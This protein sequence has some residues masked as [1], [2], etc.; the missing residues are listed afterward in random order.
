[1]ALLYRFTRLNDRANTGV[2]TFIVTRSITRDIHRDPTTKDFVYGYHRWAVSFTR[3]DKVLGVFLILRNP[4]AGTKCYVDF[5]FTLLNREHF[6][7]NE[8]FVERQCKFSTDHAAHGTGKWLPMGDLRSRKFTD[9]NMEFLMELTIGNVMT[10]FETEIKIPHSALS[11]HS[12]TAK[13]ETAFFVFGN[14][15]WNVAIHPRGCHDDGDT[16][17]RARILLNRLTGFEH[18]CRVRYRI[19]LGE[20]EKKVDSGLLDQISDLSGRIRGFWLRCQVQDIVR[21]NALKVYVEMVCAN[22]IS[23]AKLPTVRD[24]EGA[25]NCY[26]RDKQG[27]CVEADMEAECLKLK[28]FYTDLHNVPRN[29]LKYVSWNAYVIRNHPTTGHRE[30]ILVI[31]APHNSYYVQDGMDMGVTME[32]DIPVRQIR[33]MPNT[34]IEGTSNRLIVHIEWLESLLLFSA[35]YHKYDDICRVHGHQMKREISALQ[36]ENYSLERQLFSYQKSISKAGQ[37]SED[38]SDEYYFDRSLSEGQSLSETEYA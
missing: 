35:I 38:I 37:T 24:L 6:S 14:F 22:T 23:E 4:S 12:K 13:F 9:E 29:H 25:A 1:M 11:P 15:E 19:V 10:V 21:R 5:S 36:T 20:T 33:E 28:L 3:T 26:D 8:T 2:F 17:G 18:P 27:W 16:S 7:K 34:Y 32:T 31:N 30:S